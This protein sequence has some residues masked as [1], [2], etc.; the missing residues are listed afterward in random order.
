MFVA[1]PGSSMVLI[2]N[3]VVMHMVKVNNTTMNISPQSVVI[4]ILLS[5]DGHS[6]K[7]QN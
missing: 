3:S 2:K 1:G 7:I 5:T 6:S 4:P